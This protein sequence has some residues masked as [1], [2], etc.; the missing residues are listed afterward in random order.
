MK[1]LLVKLLLGRKEKYFCLLQLRGKLYWV[2]IQPYVSAED[3]MEIAANNGVFAAEDPKTE[4][5]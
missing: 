4:D 3:M 2:D 1:A 5:G